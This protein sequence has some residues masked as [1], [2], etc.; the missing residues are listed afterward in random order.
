M[1]QEAEVRI[2]FRTLDRIL[3]RY[4]IRTAAAKVTEK[5]IV[6]GFNKWYRATGDDATAYY[7]GKKRNFLLAYRVAGGAWVQIG[8]LPDDAEVERVNGVLYNPPIPAHEV[9]EVAP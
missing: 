5:R 8:K 9:P 2:A 7:A 6:S 1:A 3:N 4:G